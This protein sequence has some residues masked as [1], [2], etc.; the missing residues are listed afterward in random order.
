MDLASQHG[1]LMSEHDDL[2][3]LE[4]LGTP[5]QEHELEQPAD[6]QVG[7]RPKQEKETPRNRRDGRPTLRAPISTRAYI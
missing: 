6:S 4:L 1:Q 7:K 3:L 2:E 5:T